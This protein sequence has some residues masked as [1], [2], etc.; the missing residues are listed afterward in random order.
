MASD[1]LKRESSISIDFKFNLKIKE[2]L[3]DPDT[4]S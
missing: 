3:P 4:P 1:R 2:L